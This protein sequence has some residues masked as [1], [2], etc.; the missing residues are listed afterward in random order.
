[1][2]KNDKRV[3]KNLYE[4]ID[5]MN[6]KI[7][8]II[9]TSQFDAKW[10]S[11]SKKRQTD[12]IKFMI[13]IDIPMTKINDLYDDLNQ[14]TSKKIAK[15]SELIGIL[16]LNDIQMI[17]NVKLKD[18]SESKIRSYIYKNFSK[19]EKTMKESNIS[20]DQIKKTNDKKLVFKISKLIRL[21][22]QN[23][24]LMKYLIEMIEKSEK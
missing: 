17:E 4:M 15:R 10:I 18:Q 2:I 9:K 22:S 12:L 8:N 7:E 23:D 21:A 3:I 11:F 16:I 6:K 20:K 19:F 14:K 1:M 24:K 5:N 13:K